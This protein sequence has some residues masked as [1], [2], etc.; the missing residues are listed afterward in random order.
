MFSSS[1]VPPSTDISNNT[2]T[3]PQT[4]TKYKNYV[5]NATTIEPTQDLNYNAIDK[6][7]ENEKN[8]NKTESWN[9][10]DKTVKIQKLHAFA[11]KY[12]KDHALPVKDTKTLKAFFVDCL[13]KGKLQKTK[14]VIYERDSREITSIPALY[15]NVANRAFTLKIMDAKRVSTLKSLTPKRNT[16]VDVKAETKA[17]SYD[18]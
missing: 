15:F 17:E 11:E 4:F 5:Q 6:L 3:S 10:L 16:T 7:L 2:E 12:G 8:Q 18:K 13:E 1:V 14:D 9:K